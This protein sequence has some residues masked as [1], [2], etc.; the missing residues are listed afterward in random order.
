MENAVTYCNSKH[1]QEDFYLDKGKHRISHSMIQNDG[2]LGGWQIGFVDY[3]GQR[4]YYPPGENKFFML[5]QLQ[6][7]EDETTMSELDRDLLTA[8]HGWWPVLFSSIDEVHASQ[9]RQSKKKHN[10]EP[11]NASGQTLG[12]LPE[13]Q[14]EIA[15]WMLQDEREFIRNTHG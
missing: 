5:S 2:G 9:F 4:P 14:S 1:L 8:K 10:P 12:D 6:E 13:K 11:M 7:Y 15:N 3:N